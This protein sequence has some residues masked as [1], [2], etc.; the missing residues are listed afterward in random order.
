MSGAIAATGSPPYPISRWRGVCL[1]VLLTFAA[2]SCTDRAGRKTEASAASA[3]KAIPVQLARI[4]AQAYR[5]N[6]ESVGSL[7]PDEE[8]TVS[9]EVEGPVEQVLADV[10]DRVAK[11]QPLVKIS[12]AELTLSLEQARAAV[13]QI[14]ARLGL[15]EQGDD[16]HD[17]RAAAEVKK[18]QADLNDAEL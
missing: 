18:A 14:R 15:P 1:I 7:F 6:V 10:G 4:E 13:E 3:T 12:T 8:V 11:G 17:V 16:L 5:R 9:S 2:G